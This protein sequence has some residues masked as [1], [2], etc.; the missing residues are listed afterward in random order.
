MKKEKKLVNFGFS[1]R[2]KKTDIFSKQN[3]KIKEENNLQINPP[4]TNR[5][6]LD[7]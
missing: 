3:Q 4:L 6:I 2:K 5:I 1:A 7:H